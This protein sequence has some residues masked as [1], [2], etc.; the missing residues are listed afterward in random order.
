MLDAFKVRAGLTAALGVDQAHYQC[1]R[2]GA[3]SRQKA[4]ARW[5]LATGL[6][7]ATETGG[8]FGLRFN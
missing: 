2:S 7:E 4:T 6:T 3:R 5:R 8:L 1:S